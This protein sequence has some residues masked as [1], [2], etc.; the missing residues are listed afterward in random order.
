VPPRK[1]YRPSLAAGKSLVSFG[2]AGLPRGY[3][4]SF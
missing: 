3:A 1:R 4:R 2:I